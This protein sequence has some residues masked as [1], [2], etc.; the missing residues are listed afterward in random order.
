VTGP[1][2]KSRQSTRNYEIDRTMAYTRTPAGR[3]TRLSVAVLVDNLRTTAADGKVTETPLPP[4]QVERLTALVKDAVGFDA[5]RGD[6]VNIVNSSFAGVASIP[7]G[8]LETI[9]FWEKAWVQDLA[10]LL[11]GVIVLFVI[12]FSV[13]KPLTKGLLTQA[14]A[15]PQLLSAVSGGGNLLPGGGAGGEGQSLAYEQQVAQARG[16]VSQDPKRVAQVVKT[17][18]STDG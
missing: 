12:I 4:E 18:V 9:P 14:R 5:T 11:G 7:E 3:V 6:T 15:Q 1:D 10:K 8:E 17:W 16:L 13:L 2:S